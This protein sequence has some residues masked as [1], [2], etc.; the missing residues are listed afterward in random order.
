MATT[1]F[2]ACNALTN[3]VIAELPLVKAAYTRVMNDS[4]A[5]SGTVQLD[6]P[7]VQALNLLG[8][9]AVEPAAVSIYAL[10]DGVPTWG[11]ILWAHT[12]NLGD[13]TLDLAAAEFGS[14]LA[15]RYLTSAINVTGDM[16]TLAAGWVAAAFADGG[17]PLLASTQTCGTSVT[18]VTQTWEQHCVLDLIKAFATARGGFDW[19]FDV[20]TD[21]NGNP[22]AKFT[23]SAPRRGQSYVTSNIAFDIPGHETALKIVKDGTR[24][25]TDLFITGAGSGSTLINVEVPNPKTGYLK[26]QSVISNSDLSTLALAQAFGQGILDPLIGPPLTPALTVPGDLFFASGAGL[27]DEITMTL[28][29]P[30]LVGLLPARILAYNVSPQGAST[31]ETVQLIL[32]PV[33]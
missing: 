8:N 4:G 30:Y 2:L 32:G 20:G 17:P 12:Y 23:I 29:T 28:N 18:M 1:T 33:F 21:G 11:G 26:L 3:Q 6:D 10:R 15:F 5:M 14:Y 25:P 16:S 13:G 7:G 9:L 27:G 31:A 24:F 19:A 22:S